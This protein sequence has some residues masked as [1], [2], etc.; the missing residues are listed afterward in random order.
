MSGRGEDNDEAADDDGSKG[1]G[2]GGKGIF[3]GEI[4]DAVLGDFVVGGAED[5]TLIG[6]F[7]SIGS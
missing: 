2:E 7:Q 4:A 5:E 3:N 6:R 1:S